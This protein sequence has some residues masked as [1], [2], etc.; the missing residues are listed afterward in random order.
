MFER[1]LLG[2]LKFAQSDK[3]SF[4]DNQDKVKK[5]RRAAS[6]TAKIIELNRLVT[7]I[8][9]KWLIFHPKKNILVVGGAESD[10]QIWNLD[11][12]GKKK[13]FY[14]LKGHRSATNSGS[15]SD[16]GLLA[17]ASDDG[18]VRIWDVNE[19][20]QLRKFQLFGII[21]RLR[22]L[23]F[24]QVHCVDWSFDGK[25]L[26]AVT[27]KKEIRLWNTNS[28]EAAP[29]IKIKNNASIVAFNP[30]ENQITCD[31][32]PS[33]IGIY[34]LNKQYW[35][36]NFYHENTGFIGELDFSPDGKMLAAGGKGGVIFLY[37]V[38]TGKLFKTLFGHDVSDGQFGNSIR[39]IRF[40]PNGRWLASTSRDN[41]LIIWDMKKI[42]LSTFYKYETWPFLIGEGI[43]GLAWSFD[44]RWL[45]LPSADGEI[46][47]LELNLKQNLS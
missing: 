37:K 31:I 42:A 7:G 6:E 21:G 34:D 23:F 24:C 43:P 32:F 15:F 11:Q 8:Q 22:R 36:H 19:K 29:C 38:S 2:N 1:Q 10:I 39:S 44:S 27:E 30:K 33:H 16:N 45:A 17:T 4:L 12:D 5:M 3:I 47:I 35:T 20:R 46:Q 14:K 40:S 25:I 18:T 41:F 9:H 28:W 26:G 13:A